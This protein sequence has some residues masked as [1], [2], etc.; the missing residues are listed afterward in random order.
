MKY[1]F[2]NRFAIIIENPI[3]LAVIINTPSIFERVGIT[4]TKMKFAVLNEFLCAFFW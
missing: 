1:F 2:I 4:I 3:K